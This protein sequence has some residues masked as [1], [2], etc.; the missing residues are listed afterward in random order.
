MRSLLFLSW[1]GIARSAEE[2]CSPIN[3]RPHPAPHPPTR[4]LSGRPVSIVAYSLGARIAFLA[5][6]LLAER[7][8][9]GVVESCVLLGAPVPA[10]GAAAEAD[11]AAV[12]GVVSGRLVS[13]YSAHDWALALVYRAN[14]LRISPAAGLVAVDV[15]GVENVDF[16]ALVTGHTAYPALVPQLLDLLELQ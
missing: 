12:R 7:G 11:W 5:L 3:A 9:R 14:A 15:R 13:V 10:R 8:A 1:A 4:R 6:R 2:S 16:S